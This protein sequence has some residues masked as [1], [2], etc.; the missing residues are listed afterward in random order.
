M[1]ELGEVAVEPE[2]LSCLP[3]LRWVNRLTE[4]ELVAVEP[5]EELAVEAMEPPVGSTG[6]KLGVEEVEVPTVTT[7]GSRPREEPEVLEEE[8]ARPVTRRSMA[9]MDLKLAT[10]MTK[11]VLNLLQ[12]MG[13]EE[14]TS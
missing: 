11:R 5:E 10:R 3:V 8:L 14:V 7:T 1:P 13:P 6:T 4:S 2:A 12:L 9:V